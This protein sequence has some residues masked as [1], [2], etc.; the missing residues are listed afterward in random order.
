MWGDTAASSPCIREYHK[1]DGGVRHWSGT[2]ATHSDASKMSESPVRKLA[3]RGT[4]TCRD[5]LS[6]IARF[7]RKYEVEFASSNCRGDGF[8]KGRELRKR[9]SP[10]LEW[11]WGPL[12]VAL[13]RGP[14]P[15]F[16]GSDTR[17][18]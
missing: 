17:A 8:D 12:S 2:C 13:P 14:M 4:W 6:C 9:R 1:K 11:Y 18:K 3:V 15:D 7:N 16:E 10:E 5:T